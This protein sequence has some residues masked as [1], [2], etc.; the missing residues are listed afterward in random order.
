MTATRIWR[1]ALKTGLAVVVLAGVAELG[2]RVQQKLGPYYDLQIAPDNMD[3]HSDVVNHRPPPHTRDSLD[4][5]LYGKYDGYTYALDYDDKGIRVPYSVTGN[6]HCA[7]TPTILFMGDSFM[8]GY[9]VP[10]TVPDQVAHLLFDRYGICSRTL[11]SGHSS[12]SPAIYVPLA[13]QLLVHL[14]PDYVV[15]DIDETDLSDDVER[16][17]RL[18]TRNEKGENVGVRGTPIKY[19]L[20]QWEVAADTDLFYLQRLFDRLY[21]RYSI[22]PRIGATVA[23]DFHVSMDHDPAAREKYAAELSI[24]RRNL[25]ELMG[26][27]TRHVPAGRIV[28]IHHPQLPHLVPGPDG[29]PQWTNLVASTVEAVV[30]AHGALYY[31]AAPDLRRLAEGD[32]SALYW[33]GGDIHF[34]FDGQKAYAEAVAQFLGPEIERK[35]P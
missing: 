8:E 27:L 16:Y 17:E 19:A 30:K 23:N 31:D 18:I 7:E 10:R 32:P 15:V 20:Y 5:P 11:N 13:R 12:Y 25:E 1:L 29:Q 21:I 28:F 6:G 9:D 4:G 22:M 26:V 14:S 2:L 3:W 33:K 24:F 35:H 34:S